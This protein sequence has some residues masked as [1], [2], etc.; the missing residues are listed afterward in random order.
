MWESILLISKEWTKTKFK[1]PRTDENITQSQPHQ[2]VTLEA[3]MKESLHYPSL[4]VETLNRVFKYISKTH[5]AG[6]DEI[7]NLQR[8]NVASNNYICGLFYF[9]G[10]PCR[11]WNLITNKFF[12][13]TSLAV[14]I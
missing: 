2:R 7:S 4:R 12:F 5:H 9:V 11:I 3:T 13:Y 8:K 10:F 14:Y 6:K 1:P